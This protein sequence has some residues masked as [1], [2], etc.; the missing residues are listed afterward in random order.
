MDM[1]AIACRSSALLAR[2]LL[3]ALPRL[4][5]RL[6]LLAGFLLLLARVARISLPGL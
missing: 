3:A 4:L 2:L 6:L 5:P 1:A